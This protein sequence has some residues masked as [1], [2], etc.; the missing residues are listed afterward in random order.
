MNKRL[1]WI[2]LILVSTIF[3]ASYWVFSKVLF[4]HFDIFYHG[5][6]RWLMIIILITPFL[7]YKKE[8]VKIEKSDMK[9]FWIF[10]I[11]N[12]ATQA[13]LY[14]AYKYLDLWTWNLI[15][16]VTILLT[17]YIFWFLFLGE[18]LNKLKIISFILAIFWLFII[19]PFNFESIIL[20]A[21]ILMII[22]WVA[23]WIEVASSKKLSWKYSSLYLMFIW[24]GSVFITNMV[25]AIILWESLVLPEF[26]L[27]WW[28]LFL[29]LE[30][31]SHIHY[32]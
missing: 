13:P 31:L 32:G 12:S 17:M 26:N 2:S 8:I 11:A 16:F 4:E 22:N 23:S 6:V 24:W 9:W 20:F 10:F 30:Y 21:A 19:F 5:A 3:F 18:K 27:A 14:F 15:F 28:Y 1:K 25:L 7:M 29:Y